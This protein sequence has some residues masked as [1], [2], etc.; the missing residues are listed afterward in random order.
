MDET[1]ARSLLEELRIITS[2]FNKLSDLSFNI[3][4]DAERS[5][6]RRA[7]GMLMADCDAALIRPLERAF[8]NLEGIAVGLPDE[9][10]K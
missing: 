9:D 3:D 10:Q 6:F 2:S 1:A 8:P 5:A 7:L 4:G